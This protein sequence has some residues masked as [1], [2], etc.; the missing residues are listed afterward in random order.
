MKKW[1]AI[2]IC[3]IAVGTLILTSL[4]NVVGYQAMQASSQ[5]LIIE[6]INQKEVFFQ[7]I[8]D[9]AN[10]KEIQRIILKSQMGGGIF[11]TSDVPLVTKHQLKQ[12]YYLGVALSRF[13][14]TSRLHSMVQHQFIPPEMQQELSSAVK[15]NPLLK[16][17]IAQLQTSGCDCEN[18][19]T[20]TLS[21]PA[22]CLLLYPLA[23]LILIVYSF[24][25]FFK[26][27]YMAMFL[28]G[29]ALQCFW[30]FKVPSVDQ[31]YVLS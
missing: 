16:Q 22:L 19:N 13:V 12:M 5:D 7:T 23:V 18:E 11:P 30:G 9:I 25:P 3:I 24:T 29:A 17:E 14:S 10:N 6:R 1:L 20:T 31:N 2:G 21:F 15:N 8:V 28:V 26:L 4:S 27:L